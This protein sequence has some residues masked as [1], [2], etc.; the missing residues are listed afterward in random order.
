MQYW[1]TVLSALLVPMVAI[2]GA[3]IAYRQS[4]T[5]RNT[6]KLALFDRRL[7]VYDAAREFINA[8]RN[9]RHTSEGEFKYLSGTR[10]AIWLFNANI[11]RYLEED[12]WRK[13]ID[14][15]ALEDALKELPV[16]EERSKN[17]R[18][19]RVIKDW[20]G[21]QL[22]EMEKMFRPFVHLGG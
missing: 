21:E 2:F 15:W 5:A 16:G 7:A 17:V 3:W 12:I 19:Q 18:E 8:A 22:R 4:V 11:A 6:L 14:L 1:I 20:L 9:S 10:G 13:V